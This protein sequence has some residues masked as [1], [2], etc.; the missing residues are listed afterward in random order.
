MRVL[1]LLNPTNKRGTK[2]AYTKFKNILLE[3]GFIKEQEQLYV[4]VLT[5][6]KL[7]QRLVDGL[8]EFVPDTGTIRVL[9]LTEK[10]FDKIVY[11]TGTKSYQEQRIG[12]LDSI[13]L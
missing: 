8:K 10:Q 4:K 3:K 7:A 13:F 2:T 11:L 12:A 6:R 9:L 5:E 1:I